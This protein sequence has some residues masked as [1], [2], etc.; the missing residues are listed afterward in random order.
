MNVVITG[1]SRGIGKAIADLF[2]SN[3]HHLYLCSKNDANLSRT[4]DA[5]QVRYP[6]VNIKAKASDLSTREGVAYFADWVLDHGCTIDVLINN[7]GNFFPGSICSEQEGILE[8]ML[9]I[10]LYSA[11]DLTRKLVPVMKQ[12]KTGHIFNICSIA[13][14]KAYPQGGA[15]GISKYA[16]YGF[17]ANLREELKPTGIKVTSVFP[18]AVLTDSWGDFDN[19]TGRI[20]EATDIAQMIYAA[21][22]L[23]QQACVEDI[24]LRPQLGDL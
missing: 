18:G 16:L 9:Q 1:A 15:Y 17:S 10:N 24:V 12:Q 14:L 20:M 13:S 23:S 3:G 8:S 21:T 2:A 6:L 5:L 11:Y 19:S 7:A 22:Q 4:V